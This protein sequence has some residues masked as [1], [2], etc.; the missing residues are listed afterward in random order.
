MVA[1]PTLS[2]VTTPLRRLTIVVLVVVVAVVAAACGE[3]EEG[4]G[5]TASTGA[6]GGGGTVE[7]AGGYVL[8]S[9]TTDGETVP[10]ATADP[11]TLTVTNGSFSATTGC[12]VLNGNVDTSALPAVTFEPGPMTMRACADPA[13][14]A[15]EQA[16]VTGLP[17]VT[18]VEVDGDT[19][20]LLDEAGDVLFTFVPGLAGL[21]GTDWTATGVNTGDALESSALTEALTLGFDTEG[22]VSGNGGCN[23][24]SGSYTTEGDTIEIGELASTLIGCEPDVA[25]L[26]QQYLAALGASSTFELV[27]TTLTLRD[28][29][30][31]MQVTLTL[32]PGS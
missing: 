14:D 6:P 2:P 22:T 15:Q 9:Y 26:E 27:G 32:A 20:I 11:A 25:T 21:E 31:A 16:L 5:T 29:Q 8:E 7:L 4:S 17:L 28:D 3:D 13:V 30:A 24:F 1:R 19:T 18:D 23:S 12:N 10:A